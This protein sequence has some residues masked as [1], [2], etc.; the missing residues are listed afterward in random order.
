MVRTKD[1]ELQKCCD[2][3]LSEIESGAEC[4]LGES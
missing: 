1:W 2:L 4:E 3:G